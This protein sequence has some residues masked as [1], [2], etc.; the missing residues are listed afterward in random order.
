MTGIP[1]GRARTALSMAAAAVVAFTASACGGSGSS[2]TSADGV[3]TITVNDEPA[4]TDPVNRRIFLQDVA[5][6]EKLHPKIKVVPHEGQMD[7]QTFATK[8]AGGQLENA[9]YVYYTDPA[10]LIAKHQAADIT[11][12]LAQF[13]AVQQVKPQLRKVFQDAAGHTYGLPEG[14]YSMGLVYNRALFEQAGL[15]P[16]QPPT[17]WDEVRA[18]AKKIAGLGKGVVGYGDYS[19]SNTGGWHFTAEMYSRGGDVA[20]QQPDG[21]WKADF[22]NATG[23]AVLQQ[24][25]DMR[26]TDDSMGQRQLL[27]WAD[28]LQM[29]G[30]G[31]LGMYLATA[32]NIPTIASQYKGDPKDYGLGPIPGG[33]GTLAGGGGF[34]FNPKDTP[35]QI[36]AAL[37]WVTF[38]YE[39]PDRIDLGAQRAAQAKQPVGLPEPN[40]WTGAAASAK[41]AAD[42]K[43]AN[44]PVANYAPFEQALPGIP[45]VL[46]PPKAQQIYAVL[47]TAMAKVLTQK[48]ADIDALLSDAARQVDSLLAAQ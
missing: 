38:K 34:M 35:E 39:N 18:D 41:A 44:Q 19:K 46:E 37:A 8:L 7:P 9:F 10:G 2:G 45:L 32:D 1:A 30:S 23:R 24:L 25:H 14:N 11:P 26:W 3:V 47:D 20:K 13:P 15:D 22:D 21:S 17:T 12:Y 31:K 28:L 16:E 43:Y 42:K 27:E 36:K 29:M 5:A 40:L 4:K 6:F 33:K 48:D